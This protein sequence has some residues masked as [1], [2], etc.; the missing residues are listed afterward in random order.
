MFS[1]K[2]LLSA[3]GALEFASRVFA[4]SPYLLANEFDAALGVGE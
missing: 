4:H 1:R 2:A 3:A